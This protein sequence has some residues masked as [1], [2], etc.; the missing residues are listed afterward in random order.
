MSKNPGFSQGIELSALK[1]PSG[2]ALDLMRPGDGTPWED[3]GHLGAVKAYLNTALRSI[4]SP[5]LLMDHIRR[6]ETTADSTVF[7]IIS[8]A[9]WAVGVL[10]YNAY[11]LYVAFPKLVHAGLY[12]ADINAG[13]FWLTALLQAAMVGGGVFLWMKVGTSMFMNLAAQELKSVPHSLIYNC[14]AYATGPSLLAVVPVIGWP[15]AFALI[16]L[17]QIACGKRR[18]FMKGASA[19]INPLIIAFCVLAIAAVAYYVLGWLWCTHLEMNGLTAI[20][21]KPAAPVLAH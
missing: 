20:A 15:I 10:I 21:P 11:F 14:F 16:V 4:T 2:G 17:D 6:P 7:A 1:K 8:C 9:M 13:F 19:V 18:L 5:A 12:D 3:R